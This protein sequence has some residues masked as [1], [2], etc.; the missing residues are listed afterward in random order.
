MVRSRLVKKTKTQARVDDTAIILN[1]RPGDDVGGIAYKGER[2]KVGYS[3]NRIIWLVWNTKHKSHWEG[4]EYEAQFFVRTIRSIFYSVSAR[5][6]R[7]DFSGG[8]G[9]G[10][11][12]MRKM[13]I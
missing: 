5:C 7:Y 13:G 1:D 12:K 6:R 9:R 3:L 11:S 2:N 10:E 4:L 8:G